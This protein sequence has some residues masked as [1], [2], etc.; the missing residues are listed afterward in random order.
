[1]SR[2]DPKR[3]IRAA[4][5][6]LLEHK[7]R[8]L[9]SMLGVIFGIVSFVAMLSIGE[10]AKQKTLEQIEQ[11]GVRNLIVRAVE[12]T[13]SQELYARERLSDGLN[14]RDVSRIRNTLP[15][16]E[17]TAPV[18]EI[19][20]SV[21]SV[22]EEFFPVVLAV[23]P[24]YGEV[25]NLLTDQ[26]RFIADLDVARRQFVCVLGSD[27]AAALGE[28]GRI[29]GSVRI[30]E[31]IFRVVGILRSR[32][33][34]DRETGAVAARDF[35]RVIFIPLETDSF[36]VPS[37]GNEPFSEII[38]RVDD[39]SS[40]FA[41]AA[42]LEA[43]LERAHKGTQ[44]Y[45]L[46]IPQELLNNRRQAQANF[47]LF[48]A[49]IAV[50]SLIVGGIGIMNIMLANVSER[51]REIGIR[52]ALGANRE[53]IRWQ[54]LSESILIAAGGGVIGLVLGAVVSLVTAFF[55][56]W[57]AVIRIWILLLSLGMAVAVGLIS[58][59]YPALKASRMNPIE[60]L[61]RE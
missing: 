18:R 38:V 10:G 61:R 23:T 26:G 33:S 1:M 44:D 11:L 13:E 22:S 12:Q 5:G 25:N 29:G 28:N 39:G 60:A 35:N 34:G 21:L 24:D 37:S 59:L 47:N 2:P 6:S 45:Q 32:K 40:V 57:P 55:G 53:H 4:V 52:R 48:L 7:L 43:L 16:L 56:N 20:A 15:S 9:L 54:F 8:S 46:V 51:T 19:K 42:A 50:I 49:A 3:W 36:V 30:E 41:V 27:I 17:F 14:E 58:G 31:E